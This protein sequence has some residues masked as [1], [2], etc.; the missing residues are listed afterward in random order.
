M[1]DRH[2][3]KKFKQAA[4]IART[5]PKDFQEAAFNRALDLLLDANDSAAARPR[6]GLLA[7]AAPAEVLDRSMEALQFAARTLNRDS[8]TA[9]Q[10]AALVAAQ[11]GLA[12]SKEVVALALAGAGSAVRI[13][14]SGGITLY[15][16]VVPIETQRRIRRTAQPVEIIGALAAA[17][18]F[19]TA[20]TVTDI[21]LFLEK[22]GLDLT[23]NQIQPV[24]NR[25][26]GEGQIHLHRRS[27]GIYE[28]VD[29]EE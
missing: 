19:T 29:E 6:E 16:L 3:K 24:L 23:A 14:R 25:L 4:E 9:Q 12:V 11:F 7:A 20:R 2:I 10:I 5:V 27:K 21:A 18:F 8:L 1:A 15:K 13:V 17:G 22:R 28:Y 26:A